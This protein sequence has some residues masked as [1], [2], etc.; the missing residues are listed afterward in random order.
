[1]EEKVIL[2][3]VLWA[4]SCLDLMFG[5][6]QSGWHPVVI[7][8]KFIGFLD[9]KL[10]RGR[11]LLLKGVMMTLI[12]LSTVWSFFYI[13]IALAS[14]LSF[15]VH[16]IF[17]LLCFFF[18]TACRTLCREGLEVE[19]VL[20]KDGIAKARVQLRRIVGRDTSQLDENGIRRAVLETLSENLSDGV[21]AP[22]FW[23]ITGGISLMWLYK[24]VN[25]LDSMVG[26][27]SEKYI[28]FGKFAARTDDIMNYIPAR[29]TGL[30]MCTAFFSLK[31]IKFMFKYGSTQSSINAGYPESALAGILDCRLSGSAKYS[32]K[33]VEKPVIGDNE[34]AL[35]SE[36]IRRAVKVNYVTLLIFML[37]FTAV[38][39]VI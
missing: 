19:R 14:E 20:Q 11:F 6:P 30:L 8:G 5:D 37:I 32:G 2:L 3:A 13:S 1:M 22:L 4:G 26:Y 27:K 29:I 18:C 36:D 24:A 34:R 10:N 16:L 21:I 33:V 25:T 23:F 38:V 15:Y 17:S 31:G 39:L 28:L 9:R 12:V 35:V 7:L